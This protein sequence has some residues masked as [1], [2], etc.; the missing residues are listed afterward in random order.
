M[1]NSTSTDTNLDLALK[2]QKMADEAALAKDGLLS[3]DVEKKQTQ[4]TNSAQK[5]EKWNKAVEAMKTLASEKQELDEKTSDTSES[6][7]SQDDSIGEKKGDGEGKKSDDGEGRYNNLKSYADKTYAK[8]EKLARDLINRDPNYIHDLAKEDR[9]LADKIVASEL[10]KSHGIENYEQLVKRL[11]QKDLPE[12]ERELLNRIN[13]LENRLNSKDKEEAEKTIKA[14]LSAH[15]DVDDKQSEMIAEMV[16]KKGLTLEEAYEFSKF[17]MGHTASES[18]IR[19][20]VI[21]EL[22]AQKIAA[23][24]TT[25]SGLPEKS[26]KKQLTDRELNFL[27]GIGA[28]RT[29]AKYGIK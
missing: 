3:T 21:K 4:D 24:L 16:D 11:E 25:S 27:E 15:P 14:F 22:D 2:G 7:K 9:K 18:Q 13:E 29:L 23:G 12:N 17:K 1:E 19:E 20:K 5:G 6:K 10:G 28:K 8:A 26:N